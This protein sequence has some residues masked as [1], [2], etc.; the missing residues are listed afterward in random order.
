M[1]YSAAHARLLGGERGQT[2]PLLALVLVIMLGS[3][4]IV[5]D[6]GRAYVV[7]RGLQSSADAAALAAAQ[8]LP[9]PGDA[10]AVAEAYGGEAGAKNHRTEFPPVTTTATTECRAGKPCA[11]VN[12]VVVKETASVPTGFAKLFGLEFFDVSARAVAAIQQGNVPWAI[13][14]HDQ[15]CG[16]L[17]FRYNGNVFDVEGGIHSNGNFEVNGMNITGGY[18]SSGGPNDCE[19]TLD[20]DHIDFDGRPEPV[21]DPSLLD[22]PAYFETDEF[23]CT[24]SAEEFKFN[25]HNVDIPSGVYCA[26]KLFEMNANHV[27]GQITVLAPEIK[28]DGNNQQLSP[29]LKDVLF[30][31][32]G[33]KE[34][35][36]NG[37]S[38]NWSG[39]IFHPGGRVKINGNADSFLNGMIEARQVE[40]NGNAFRMAG[41]GPKTAGTIIALVE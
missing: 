17:V 40:V 5:V 29:Y 38:Y 26:S 14:A 11:P 21:R 23:P 7:Q 35:V 13:F 20:G 25:D 8:E 39:I 2:L 19:P 12:A 15:D 16:S 31:A 3:A 33:S 4:A 37:N 30:F 32:T 41:D 34:M 6:L 22:W 36:L 10:V 9:D 18:A 28:A 27:K 24:Y 1:R